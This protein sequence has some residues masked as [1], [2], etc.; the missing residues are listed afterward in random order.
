MK[1]HFKNPRRLKRT[2]CGH[3][4]TISGRTYSNITNRLHKVDCKACLK[5]IMN[6]KL[7]REIYF[8][9]RWK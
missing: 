6:N 3:D 5:A 2:M 9:K 4:C 1:I 7:T 8:E